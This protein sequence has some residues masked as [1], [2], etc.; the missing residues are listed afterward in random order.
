MSVDQRDPLDSKP[1][2]L[3]ET[4]DETDAL[5]EELEHRYRRRQDT[6]PGFRPEDL[7]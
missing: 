1:P 6:S 5:L 2:T 4:C 7:R 3:E